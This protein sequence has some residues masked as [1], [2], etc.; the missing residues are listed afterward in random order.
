MLEILLQT[1]ERKRLHH[2]PENII[3]QLKK[4]QIKQAKHKTVADSI[5]ERLDRTQD[6]EGKR[7]NMDAKEFSHVNEIQTPD[8]SRYPCHKDNFSHNV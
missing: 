2:I 8:T 4:K 3:Q 5:T 7:S 6:K 1:H